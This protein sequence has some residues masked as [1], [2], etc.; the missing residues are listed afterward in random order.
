MSRKMIKYTKEFKTKLVLEVLQGEKAINEIVSKY[1][2]IL[3]VWYYKIL[4]QE[5]RDCSFL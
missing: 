4:Y 3:Y 1:N 5:L 2:I